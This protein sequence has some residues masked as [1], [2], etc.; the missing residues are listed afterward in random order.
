MAKVFDYVVPIRHV[1][2][3]ADTVGAY[4]RGDRTKLKWLIN[5]SI[6]AATHET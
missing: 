5:F 1:N 2:D 6:T 4:L 3:L